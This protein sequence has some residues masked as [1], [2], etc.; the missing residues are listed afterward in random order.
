[1]NG[2]SNRLAA[3]AAAALGIA[4]LAPAS[5]AQ[6]QPANPQPPSQANATANPSNPGPAPSDAELKNFAGA[7]VQ[8]QSIRQSLQPQLAAAKTDSDR[9]QL[10]AT[11]EQK[12]E[13]AVRD[14]H[15]S[16]QRYVQIAQVVQTNSAVRAKVQSFMPPLPQPQS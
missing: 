10:K 8:V 14:H 15:L 12:M 2:R 4:M 3:A 13:T 16:L 1:M 5:F 9:T 7:A 6:S 11:A